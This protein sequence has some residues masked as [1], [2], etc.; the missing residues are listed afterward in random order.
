MG[1]VLL[2]R[3]SH[4]GYPY[5]TVHADVANFGH[6][7]LYRAALCL[8]DV[9]TWEQV[10]IISVSIVTEESVL[11]GAGLRSILECGSSV[12]LLAL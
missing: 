3:N 8:G 1:G 2:G 6:A 9:P 11:S 7:T 10:S 12:A 4:G 5:F